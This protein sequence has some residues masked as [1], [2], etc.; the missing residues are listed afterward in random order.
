MKFILAVV[1]VLMTV[2]LMVPAA[3]AAGP[4]GGGA[5]LVAADASEKQ[6]FDPQSLVGK[7][8]GTWKNP[9]YRSGTIVLVL[10][11]GKNG[12]VEIEGLSSGFVE[13]KIAVTL[14]VEKGDTYL[15]FYVRVRPVNLQ[16]S[17]KV[18]DK[19]LDGI[20]SGRS[21]STVSLARKE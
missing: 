7:W 12:S 3:M 9:V 21:T 11:D 1:L 5:I 10:T 2:V 6:V 15:V 4:Q 13:E 16:F 19:S 20:M 18:G 14:Q 17:L 8:I